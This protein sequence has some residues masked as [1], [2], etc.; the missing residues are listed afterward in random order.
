MPTFWRPSKEV[1]GAAA[2]TAPPVDTP[3]SAKCL[4]LPAG[5]ASPVCP[6]H[7]SLTSVDLPTSFRAISEIGKKSRRP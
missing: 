7:T 3:L 1:M 2:P 6:V 4:H 5:E